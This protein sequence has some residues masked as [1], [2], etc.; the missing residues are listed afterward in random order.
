MSLTPSTTTRTVLERLF[1]NR[2]SFGHILQEIFL[3]LDSRTLKNLRLCNQDLRQFTD[4]ILWR[5]SRGKNRLF[6][7]L[8]R[9]WKER[10]SEA[11]SESAFQCSDEVFDIKIRGDSII[12]GLRNGTIELWDK[13]TLKKTHSLL[14]QNGSVQVD[15]DERFV[16]G[17]SSDSTVCFW[18]RATGQFI[19][20]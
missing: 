19:G 17:I 15:A 13:E 11:I 18:S 2:V 1:A 10:N 20:N 12:C 7:K 5:N 16:V 4:R 3:N 14:D 6:H 9:N 8:T